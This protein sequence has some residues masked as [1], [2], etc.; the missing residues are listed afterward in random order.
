VGVV[1]AYVS[2]LRMSL[3]GTAMLVVGVA[4]YK[5][6]STTIATNSNAR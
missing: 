6:R 2:A 3:A 5:W 4:V 1:S